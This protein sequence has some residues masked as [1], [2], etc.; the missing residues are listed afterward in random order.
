MLA[1]ASLQ[2]RLQIHKYYSLTI[3]FHNVLSPRRVQ[4]KKN[5]V[6]LR[7]QSCLFQ[8]PVQVSQSEPIS[9]STGALPTA[10]QKQRCEATQ[11]NKM[12][13]HNE[14]STP[15]KSE[16]DPTLL[17]F[18]SFLVFNMFFVFC[19]QYFLQYWQYQDWCCFWYK[20]FFI[21]LKFN[22]YNYPLMNNTFFSDL[23]IFKIYW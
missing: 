11:W 23:K 17:Q 14:F 7:A 12:P 16:R 5:H 19:P 15:T 10:P 9:G 2:S 18:Q 13:F 21:A 4:E 20:I 6:P 22:L 1:K 3:K 8:G